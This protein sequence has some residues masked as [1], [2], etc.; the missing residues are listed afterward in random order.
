MSTR[1]KFSDARWF[2]D[3]RPLCVV[4]NE[5]KRKLQAVDDK[6]YAEKLQV[7]GLPLF[8]ENIRKKPQIS[9][10]EKV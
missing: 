6:Q 4:E 1:M 10:T 8:Q 7:S 5:M 2:S 3:K 9:V